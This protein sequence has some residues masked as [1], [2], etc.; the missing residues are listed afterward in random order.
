MPF[1]LNT[2]SPTGSGGAVN[3]DKLE[4]AVAEY[5]FFPSIRLIKPF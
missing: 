1:G 5:V 2:S 4:A 3:H